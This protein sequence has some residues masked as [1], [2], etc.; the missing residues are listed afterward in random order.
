MSWRKFHDISIEFS[1]LAEGLERGQDI[2]AELKA[3]LDEQ[4]E[5][6]DR[7]SPSL[8]STELMLQLYRLAAEAEEE[9][10]RL[11]EPTKLKT[12]GISAV[13]AASLWLKAREF[14]Q[15][16]RACDYWIE[17]AE[18][19]E[20]PDFGVADLEELLNIIQLRF[21][22]RPEDLFCPGE[23]IKRRNK[24]L[25]VGRSE[26][27]KEALDLIESGFSLVITGEKS[28][29]KTSFAWQFM[30]LLAGES[31]TC[32]RWQWSPNQ[33]Y[34]CVWLDCTNK[35]PDLE[36]VLISLLQ[37]ST[38]D[39]TFSRNFPE[40]YDIYWN[41][42]VRKAYESYNTTS[43][44]IQNST[45][46]YDDPTRIKKNNLRIE[47]RELF[48]EIQASFSNQLTIIF[49]DSCEQIESYEGLG[50]LIIDSADR[51][52][53]LIRFVL[54]GNCQKFG[55]IP[56]IDDHHSSARRLEE[57]RMSGLNEADVYFLL[58]RLEDQY[59]HTI[60]WSKEFRDAFIERLKNE[61][62]DISTHN[63]SFNPEM[64]QLLGYYSAR[65]ALENTTDSEEC[66]IITSNDLNA[67]KP[68]HNSTL[69]PIKSIQSTQKDKKK[70]NV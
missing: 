49:L 6:A 31:E 17:K 26:E 36:G 7:L 40:K 37:P 23:P 27:M 41:K 55:R 54:I 8:N 10:L 12:R 46:K 2:K 30:E 24:D 22:L 65:K 13:R 20:F 62:T 9:A 52:K 43:N 47:I 56:I 14:R 69:K 66:L 18:I 57:L 59:F 35:M 16:Q 29:G 45:D 32:D 33:P 68:S 21:D 51:E 28:V 5:L 58:E 50:K 34:R 48:R 3:F 61:N 60:S 11:L 44:D 25:F 70:K 1:S 15:T 64:V 4:P 19:G 39:Y 63:I 67:V 38:R 53:E 42:K